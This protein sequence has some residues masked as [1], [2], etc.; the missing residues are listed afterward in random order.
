MFV[1]VILDRAHNINKGKLNIE[2]LF[3]HCNWT[4]QIH[5]IFINLRG[6]SW[7]MPAR[8]KEVLYSWNREGS[9][10]SQEENGGLSQHGCMEKA[11]SMT[12]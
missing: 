8:A 10:S 1:Q 7:V 6:I 4:A 12:I 5:R 11:K 3:L 2:H 9:W